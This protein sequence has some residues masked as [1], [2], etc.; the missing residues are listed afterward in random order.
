MHKNNAPNR[1]Y[2][3][4]VLRG[5]A[6]LCVV[7]AHWGEFYGFNKAHAPLSTNN[8]FLSVVLNWFD[9]FGSSAVD[10]FF[11]ISGFVFFW[12]YS[13]SIYQAKISFTKFAFLR[14]SRL[15]PLHVLTLLLVAVIQL[16]SAN[17]HDGAMGNDDAHHFLLNLFFVSAWGLDNSFSFN[18]PAWSVSVEIFLYS[19][20]FTLCWLTPK[21]LSLLLLL[22]LAG[23]FIVIKFN[24]L[25]GRGIESFY[26]GGCALVIYERI[27]NTKNWLKLSWCLPIITL[28]MW[29]VMLTLTSGYPLASPFYSSG[30][31][32][33]LLAISVTFILF[34]MTVLSLVLM[35]TKNQRMGKKLASLGDISYST[36]LLHFPLQLILLNIWSTFAFNP[37]WFY[38]ISFIA[39]FFV[40]LIAVSFL[41]YHYFEIPMQKHLRNWFKQYQSKLHLLA[42]PTTVL[43][44]R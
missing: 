7:L 27:K 31:M 30:I 23:H 4:D 6:S 36:Y 38:S 44:L 25:I 39:A 22:A 12:L 10:L 37:A 33:K 1:F 15:Y 3:L 19:L 42:Y 2:S 17:L 16:Y 40:V 11:C 18:F 26:L 43:P 35:E 14:L 41:S 28:A 5:L 9:T 8:Q 20:F 29:C 21:K 32:Q 13:S 34:P 24:Y